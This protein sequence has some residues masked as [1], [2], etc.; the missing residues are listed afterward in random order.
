MCAEHKDEEAI[1]K[2]AIKLESQAER[3]IYL[4]GACGD[5]TELLAR[6]GV[7]LK[8]HYE[9]GVF[10][11]VPG[12]EPADT[13]DDP[14]V[15][16][17]LGTVI[18][19]YKLLEKIGEGGMGSVYLALRLEPF[20][21]RVAIKIV[22]RGM[23]TDD[24]LKR[25]HIEQQIHAALGEH[26]NIVAVRDAGVT[27]DGRP[28]FVMDYIEGQPIDEYCDTRELTI[29]E[30]IALFDSVLSAVTYAHQNLIIHRDLKPS[31]I[32][33]TREGTAVLVDFG[34]AKLLNPM[35]ADQMDAFTI[36]GQRLLT[37]EYASPEQI[38]ADALLTTTSDVYSLGV[39]LY[40]LLTGHPPY[41]SR[42][43]STQEMQRIICEEQP[44][45]PSAVIS[46]TVTVHRQDGT[47]RTLNPEDIS[48]RRRCRQPGQLS[49]I[50]TGDAETI[51]LFAL[52]KEPQRRYPSVK[53]LSID[54][55][56]YLEGRP[57]R[58]ARRVATTERV[59]LWFRRNPKAVALTAVI[60]LL[61]AS[62]DIAL[63]WWNLRDRTKQVSTNNV[64]TARSAAITV[65][66][67]WDR[68]STAVI[69]VAH[70]SELQS[71]IE[72]NDIDAL[73]K[74]IEDVNEYYADPSKGYA[75]SPEEDP[76]STWWV[77]A[78]NG[79]V[80][81]HSEE[82]YDDWFGW[83]GYFKGAKGL[84]EDLDAPPSYVS[85]V[86]QSLKGRDYYKFA[87]S[88]PIYAGKRRLL[89]VLAASVTTDSTKDLLSKNHRY[90]EG[91]SEPEAVLVGR[92]DPN[93][94]PQ[95][96][97]QKSRPDKPYP[98]HPLDGF[99]ILGH[100]TFDAG[101]DAVEIENDVLH[102]VANQQEPV[103]LEQAVDKHYKDPLVPKLRNNKDPRYM[104]Y[105][106]RW[107][108]GFARV[109]NT[110]FVVIV[111]QRYDRAVS[112]F[113]ILGRPLLLWTAILMCPLA[114]FLG[115]ILWNRLQKAWVK[116][117]AA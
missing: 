4:K 40:E 81:A 75:S 68:L 99:L 56:S 79:N 21:K 92:W 108:A 57:L 34:I 66:E 3:D 69:Q 104:D 113:A 12:F 22:K 89:G 96:L 36:A 85:K 59:C 67:H 63:S 17:G 82:D 23:D 49:R 62:M 37:P 80:L 102:R 7:L 60:L 87:I 97:M 54:L 88:V 47:T 105:Q 19:H 10:L 18:G 101:E 115:A 95:V 44:Q 65:R 112:P 29:R 45:K 39:V 43:R 94:P 46:T 53:A 58:Y 20:K 111:Q 31:N 1:F 28:Y 55:Q 30:R 11:E 14:L 35:L 64:H 103:R 50:L 114:M 74:W 25:F 77:M 6:I 38:R 71:L 117:N 98:D 51:L 61:L 2:A 9:A 15:T 93:E 100:P 116:P 5:N 107:L 41:R 70:D 32:L 110:D 83:R 106:G 76:F 52:L 109:P 84:S 26:P 86:Y 73:R 13:L 90:G 8:G 48:R 24:I 42:N 72:S 33:V 16:E 27:E 91:H 78:V